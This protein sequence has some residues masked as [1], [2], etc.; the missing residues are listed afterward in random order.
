M[1]LFIK[2]LTIVDEFDNT[3]YKAKYCR[4][5]VGLKNAMDIVKDKQGPREC[6]SIFKRF[7]RDLDTEFKEYFKL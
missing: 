4:A 3:I 7:L 6:R 5:E 2:D 1:G